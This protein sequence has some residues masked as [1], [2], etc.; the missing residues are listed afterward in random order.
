MVTLFIL[1]QYNIQILRETSED[2]ELKGI[3]Y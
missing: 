2:K 1:T 3:K